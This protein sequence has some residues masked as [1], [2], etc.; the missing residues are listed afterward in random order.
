MAFFDFLALKNKLEYRNDRVYPH[1]K[2]NGKWI[3][4]IIKETYY[5]VQPA[6]G[7]NASVYDMALWLKGLL[8]GVPNIISLDIIEEVCKPIIKTP[9]ERNR[10]NWNI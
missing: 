2:R 4:T 10:F 6:A 5:N 8:G 7:I 9:R 1:I 3:P